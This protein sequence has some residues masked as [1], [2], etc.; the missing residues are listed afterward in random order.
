M[1]D[2]M[3]ATLEQESRQMRARNERLEKENSDLCEMVLRQAKTIREFQEEINA[4]RAREG[5]DA[6]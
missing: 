5:K 3:I 4:S 1:T 2:D 6:S